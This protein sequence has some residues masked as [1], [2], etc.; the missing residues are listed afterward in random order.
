MIFMF[1]LLT[2]LNFNPN[3]T[4][5]VQFSLLV[6]HTNKINPMHARK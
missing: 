5:T 6:H 4:A 1:N 2:F 3:P